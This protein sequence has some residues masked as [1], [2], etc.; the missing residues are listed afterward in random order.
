MEFRIEYA[1]YS[2]AGMAF[3][4]LVAWRVRVL[5]SAYLF[6]AVGIAIALLALVSGR[7]AERDRTQRVELLKTAGA[8]SVALGE[9][10]E[11][12]KEVHH[13]VKNSLQVTSSLMQLQARQFEDAK[14]REAFGRAQQRL[15][16]IG[17]IHDTFFL[18][19][20]E[21][22]VDMGR[23]I[24]ELTSEIAGMYEVSERRIKLSFDV[25]PIRMPTEK[26]TPLALCASEVLV[27]VFEHAF[28]N[29][30]EGNVSIRMK[31]HDDAVELDIN[32]DG[33]GFSGA[34]SNGA[35]GLRLVNAFATQLKGTMSIDSRQGTKFR[36]EFPLTSIAA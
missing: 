3:F 36:L 11:L 14:V 5:D 31:R 24:E 25:D 4:A 6:V 18:D 10:N 23:Y 16:A 34:P 35:L 8:L 30:R 1:I 26:A 27:N 22:T 20:A 15:R 32:D 21:T 19:N 12:L 13:R 17:M 28:D 7:L 33:S 2:L 9:R 29:R